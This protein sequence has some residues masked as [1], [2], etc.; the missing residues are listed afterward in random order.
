MNVDQLVAESVAQ[1]NQ[2]IADLGGRLGNAAMAVAQL[3]EENAMLK[4]KLSETEKKAKNPT[5]K[6]SENAAA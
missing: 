6:E 3:R 2:T 4:D 1:Y 5:P